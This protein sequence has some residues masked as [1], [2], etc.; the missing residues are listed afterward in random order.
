[1]VRTMLRKRS[2]G[3]PFDWGRK[4]GQALRKGRAGNVSYCY[5]HCNQRSI[6]FVLAAS[7]CVNTRRLVSVPRLGFSMSHSFLRSAMQDGRRACGVRRAAALSLTLCVSGVLLRKQE[8]ADGMRSLDL[9]HVGEDEA[10]S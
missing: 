3:N 5:I 8:S 7:H 4:E 6:S 10:L 9:P 1:M 2:F